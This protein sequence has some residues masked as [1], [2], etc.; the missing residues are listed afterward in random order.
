VQR[1]ADET[2][3]KEGE[4]AAPAGRFTEHYCP[5]CHF[6]LAYSPPQCLDCHATLPP[7]KPTGRPQLYC[8]RSCRDS[9]YFQRRRYDV[10]LNRTKHIAHLEALLNAAHKEMARLRDL[11][12]TTTEQKGR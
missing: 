11:V 5:R 10:E 12:R 4:S 3:E 6:R 1:Y 8:N 2:P 9:A 7:G